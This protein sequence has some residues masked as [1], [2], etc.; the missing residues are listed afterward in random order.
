MVE[1]DVAK[2]SP[3][4]GKTAEFNLWSHGALDG[5]KG[6]VNTTGEFA[7]DKY[8]LSPEGWGNIN[9]NWKDEGAKAM[10]Y[11]CRSACAVD[12]KGIPITSWAQ[13]ISMNGNMKNVEVWGQ[14][15]RSWPSLDSRDGISPIGTH[16]DYPTYM[17]GGG[18]RGGIDGMYRR[19]S[20]IRPLD[21]P[22]L[23][24]PMRKYMNG[25]CTGY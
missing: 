23:K 10:F 22:Y 7:L 19:L 4:Y 14:T 6:G 20:S 15:T 8:H 1:S 2:Y 12:D 5:P 11:G 16:H 9:F 13:T 25:I 3:E 18:N 24:Y 17:L 21:M